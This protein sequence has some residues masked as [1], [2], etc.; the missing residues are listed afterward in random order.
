MI[1]RLSIVIRLLILWQK[2]ILI[3]WVADVVFL[4]FNLKSIYYVMYLVNVWLHLLCI[5]SNMCFMP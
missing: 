5:H 4:V 1:G 3:F 2:E